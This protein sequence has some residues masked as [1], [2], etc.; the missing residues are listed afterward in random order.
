MITHI[1][2]VATGRENIRNTPSWWCNPLRSSSHLEESK[3]RSSGVRYLQGTVNVKAKQSRFLAS[4]RLLSI[5]RSG[6]AVII[7]YRLCWNDPAWSCS[8]MFF[9]LKIKRVIESLNHV[10]I[11]GRGTLKG[12]KWK[13]RRQ[14]FSRCWWWWELRNLLSLLSLIQDFS[15]VTSDA[16]F[17]STMT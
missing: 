8:Y 1:K 15:A 6:R 17:L 12:Q 2:D 10:Q 16:Q 7:H 5:F 14:G 3:C 9:L 4:H 13:V 11:R